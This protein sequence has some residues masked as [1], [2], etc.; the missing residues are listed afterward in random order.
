MLEADRNQTEVPFK[1]THSR[2]REGRYALKVIAGIATSIVG[3][4]AMMEGVPVD[5][6]LGAGATAVGF[7]TVASGFNDLIERIPKPS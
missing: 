1:M 7:G 2:V 5:L 4:K 3:A 6:T